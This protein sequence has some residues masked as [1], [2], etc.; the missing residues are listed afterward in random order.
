MEELILQRI[1]NYKNHRQKWIDKQKCYGWTKKEKEE[2]STL[3]GSYQEK[4]QIFTYK[5][6]ELEWVL[7]IMENKVQINAFSG[8]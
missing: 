7:G 2:G 6:L 3:Y 8:K 4:E 1:E 5:I